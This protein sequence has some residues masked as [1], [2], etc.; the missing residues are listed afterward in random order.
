MNCGLAVGCDELIKAQGFASE[1]PFSEAKW[2]IIH[3]HDN[4]H[5]SLQLSVASGNLGSG[6]GDG[7]L[8]RK[9][10]FSEANIDFASEFALEGFFRSKMEDN[11]HA[12]VACMT[13]CNFQWPAGI[14]GQEEGMAIC[15]GNKLFPK[16]ILILVW[17]L[18][19]KGFSEAKWKPFASETS[20]FR[21]KFC[22][23]LTKSG[24]NCFLPH[25]LQSNL[26]LLGLFGANSEEKCR[27]CFYISFRSK[28]LEA[29][30]QNFCSDSLTLCWL[31]PSDQYKVE[32]FAPKLH[33]FEFI[34]IFPLEFSNLDFPLLETADVDVI[35]ASARSS[36][37]P[38]MNM[39]RALYHA[40]SLCLSFR[41]IEAFKNFE[42]QASPFVRLKT[43]KVRKH[44]P[45]SIPYNLVSY[46]DRGTT[47]GQNLS[48]EIAEPEIIDNSW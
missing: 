1:H 38:L 29:K 2:K 39:F 47:V 46:F 16:Q 18:L 19:R 5:D 7:H 21:S 32:I 37:R 23:G 30:S 36:L 33:S 22:F 48:I 17:N 25:I 35:C 20:F 6:R 24:A 43:L 40:Q 26:L 44:K 34:D 13:V 3:L 8:L 41:T 10:A 28:T 14:S 31:Y 9:Q 12:C 42:D 15:F 45:L 27:I 11:S 4:M